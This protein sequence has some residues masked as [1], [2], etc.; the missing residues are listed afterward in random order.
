MGLRRA[1]GPWV[2]IAAPAASKRT[3]M[4]FWQPWVPPGM[5]LS[6]RRDMRLPGKASRLASEPSSDSSRVTVSRVKKDRPR[7]RTRPS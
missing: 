1:Q 6:R 7:C 3:M 5:R 4:T 2:V